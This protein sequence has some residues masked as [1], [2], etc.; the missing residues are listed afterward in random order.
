MVAW[1]AVVEEPRLRLKGGGDA[2]VVVR[3]SLLWLSFLSFNNLDIYLVLLREE[4]LV[5]SRV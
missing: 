5:H 2:V 1:V 3:C 4:V